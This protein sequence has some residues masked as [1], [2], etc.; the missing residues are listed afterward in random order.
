MHSLCIAKDGPLKLIFFHPLYSKC[1]YT[2]GSVPGQIPEIHIHQ[3]SKPATSTSI[4]KGVI[5]QLSSNV[6][7]CFSSTASAAFSNLFTNPCAT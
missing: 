6:F 5:P 3:L 2:I 1:S 4:S 7:R